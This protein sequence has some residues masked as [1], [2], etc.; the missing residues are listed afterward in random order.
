MSVSTPHFVQKFGPGEIVVSRSGE[1]LRQE[2]EFAE[3]PALIACVLRM[4]KD[5]GTILETGETLS[6][7][8]LTFEG[9]EYVVGALDSETDESST[10]I[11][12]KRR[13]V[14]WQLT[15]QGT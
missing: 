1:I 11:H 7:L 10:E 5:V 3:P 14:D 15:P 8:M 9:V 12:I 13:P 6:R 2:G 4:L